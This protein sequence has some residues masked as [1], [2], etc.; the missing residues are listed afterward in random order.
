MSL[1]AVRFDNHDV[2]VYMTSSSGSQ[3]DLTTPDLPAGEYE[4]SVLTSEGLSNSVPFTIIEDIDPTSGVTKITNHIEAAKERLLHQ[5][6]KP[7]EELTAPNGEDLKVENLLQALYTSGVQGFEDAAYTIIPK[8]VVDDNE[9]KQLDGIGDIVGQLRNGLEDDDYKIYLKGKI[10]LNNSNGTLDDIYL[11]W[12]AFSLATTSEILEIFPA[13][14][15][16]QSDTAPPSKYL[17]IIKNYLNKALGAAI[18]LTG[19]IIYDTDEA[20]AFSDTGSSETS[21]THGFSDL[22]QTTG[23]KL[24]ELI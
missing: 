12:N 22:A 14:V 15:Q 19:I 16:I 6:L 10:G 13:S 7:H 23:G 4:V 11:I 8:L 5:Y 20:F 3:I 21:T 2:T 1:I 24:S 17:P 18:G 9:G